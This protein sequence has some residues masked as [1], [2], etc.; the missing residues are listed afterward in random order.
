MHCST[1]I[2]QLLLLFLSIFLGN[3]VYLVKIELPSA[4]SP[5]LAAVNRLEM[6]G[7]EWTSVSVGPQVPVI[8]ERPLASVVLPHL[9]LVAS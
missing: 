7:C 6:W 3:P 5:G 8:F 2:N 4:K 9:F 1:I